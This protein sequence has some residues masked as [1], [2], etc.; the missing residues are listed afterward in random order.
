MFNNFVF[1]WLNCNYCDNITSNFLNPNRVAMLPYGTHDLSEVHPR[2]MRRFKCGNLEKTTRSCV[3]NHGHFSNDISSN[4]WRYSSILV[5]NLDERGIAI[6]QPF[7][8]KRFNV[9]GK[10]EIFTFTNAKSKRKAKTNKNN[11]NWMN[12]KMT[13]FILI[14]HLLKVN[15]A[16]MQFNGL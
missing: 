11:S 15:V 4:N 16:I 2:K 9:D 8:I 6:W 5:N 10:S 3:S 1:L 12:H 7:N 13:T 14:N